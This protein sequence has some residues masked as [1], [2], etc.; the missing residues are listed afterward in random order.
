MVM[1]ALPIYV[2]AL[3][4]NEENSSTSDLL[5]EVSRSYSMAKQ[6]KDKG[7]VQISYYEDGELV[8]QEKKEF[9]TNFERGK[10][11][12]IKWGDVVENYPG[13][14]YEIWMS[15][16]TTYSKYGNDK[17]FTSPSLT[18][19]LNRAVGIST[20]VTSYI[21]CLLLNDTN[22]FLCNSKFEISTENKDNNSILE[23]I[24][25]KSRDE[26]VEEIWVDVENKLIK[27]IEWWNQRGNLRI[28]HKIIY[29]EIKINVG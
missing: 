15:N 2:G 7:S 18:S 21:P 28:H 17:K 6:Y 25:I 26:H 24:K 3:Q 19:A 16:G 12:H 29:K 22:C 5:L 1:L 14:Q 8:Q 23:H 13:L 11:F 27:R 9:E 10:I 20:S 4:A